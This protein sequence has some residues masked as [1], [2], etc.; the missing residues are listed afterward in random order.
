MT[1]KTKK[2]ISSDCKFCIGG[3]V[4][5]IDGELKC[6][7]CGRPVDYTPANKQK[8]VEPAK[9]SYPTN[10]RKDGC[11][12]A[13]IYLGE[14]SHCLENCPF[15]DMCYHDNPKAIWARVRNKRNGDK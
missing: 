5:W 8:A 4:R 15:L 2:R 10:G 7:N 9:A 1:T 3:K 12:A 6:I 13:T 11:R 14:Q